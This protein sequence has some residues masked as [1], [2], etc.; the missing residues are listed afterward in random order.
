[1]QEKKENAKKNIAGFRLPPPHCVT[2]SA[3]GP[4]A[5]S[6]PAKARRPSESPGLGGGRVRG[7]SGDRVV[8][9]QG[10]GFS[11]GWA[12]KLLVGEKAVDR[13]PSNPLVKIGVK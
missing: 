8:S 1:M 4:S 7:W 6:P 2:G 11:P 3:S 9:S 10:R 5:R 13:T 12:R